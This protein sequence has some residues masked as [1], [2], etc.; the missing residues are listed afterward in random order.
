[1]GRGA[2]YRLWEIAKSQSLSS[3][4]L[5]L[6]ITLFS[7]SWSRETSPQ[8]SPQNVCESARDFFYDRDLCTHYYFICPT[9]M[10]KG[11]SRLD[12]W[13]HKNPWELELSHRLSFCLYRI[14]PHHRDGS[15]RD[16]RHDPCGWILVSGPY[17]PDH[18]ARRTRCHARE[19]S[20]ILDREMVWSRTHRKIWRLVLTWKNRSSHTPSAA[21]NKWIL[22]RCPWKIS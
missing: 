16:E 2:S 14:S 15:T 19:L 9:R 4:F 18:H 3:P 13:A 17:H 8:I 12:R 20:R 6:Q 10:D 21:R 1:M 7:V 11:M 22:V 5:P